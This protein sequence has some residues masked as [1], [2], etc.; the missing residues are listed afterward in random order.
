[1]NQNEAKALVARTALE[2]LPEQGVIGLGSGSTAKLFIDGVA[3]LVKQGRNLIGVP[4]SSTSR[5]QAEF[6][7]IPLLTE[8]GPWPI[9]V[10]VDGADQV[11]PKLD[12]IK[13]G[14]G[15]HT[16]EKVVNA[17]AKKNIIIVDES[18]L[19]DKLGTNFP[20]P[21]EVLSFGHHNTAAALNHFGRATLRLVNSA[22]F[23]TDEG[24]YIYDVDCGRI[25]SPRKLDRALRAVAGVVETGLFVGRADIVLVG[26]P[27]GVRTIQR[28]AE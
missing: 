25:D 14:G 15:F 21:V 4:T 18:K 22:P 27:N 1:M 17:A 13:G 6:L 12:L 2:Y 11:C 28:P 20:V 3:Q 23:K 9:E 26:G 10:C 19:V 24:R 16:R 5:R 7:G 8:E